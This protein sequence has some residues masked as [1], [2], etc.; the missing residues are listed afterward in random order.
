LQFRAWASLLALL[1][2][3]AGCAANPVVDPPDT[4]PAGAPLASMVEDALAVDLRWIIV[5]DGPG[6]WVQYADWDEYLLMLHN[7]E[8][9]PIRF[10]SAVVHD[11]LGTPVEP[12]TTLDA[13]RKGTRLAKRRY[14]ASGTLVNPG[15]FDGYAAAEV[16]LT[17]GMTAGDPAVALLS[18][19]AALVALPVIAVKEMSKN[20]GDR[21][22]DAVI[23]SR[24][25]PLPQVVPAHAS[26]EV[27]LF[28]PVTPSPQ[29]VDLH[30]DDGLSVRIISIDTSDLLAGLHIAA[31]SGP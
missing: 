2:V 8:D 30:F 24:Q 26:L 12:A 15:T 31:E 16:L 23:K 25:T 3:I 17:V 28:F 13:L 18:M 7:H 1:L 22:I 20:A 27:T 4:R 5:R 29:Q 10:V 21:K 11:S 9:G 6:S 14:E 19:A